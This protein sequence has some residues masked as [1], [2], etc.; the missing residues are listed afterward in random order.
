MDGACLCAEKRICVLGPY[1]ERMMSSLYDYISECSTI[2]FPHK[3]YTH[4]SVERPSLTAQILLCVYNQPLSSSERLFNQRVP[5]G[6]RYAV[7]A[8]LN[9]EVD[10]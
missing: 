8:A 6:E 10:G 2:L 9:D 5:R 4:S 1:H 3:D 7:V